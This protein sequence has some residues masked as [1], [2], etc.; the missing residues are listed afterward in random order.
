MNEE[1]LKKILFLILKVIIKN[2]GFLSQLEIFRDVRYYMQKFFNIK[3]SDLVIKLPQGR[4]EDFKDIL[5]FILTILCEL[6]IVSQKMENK[7]FYFKWIGFKGFRKKYLIEFI[8]NNQ[9]NFEMSDSFEHRI[10]IY[11]RM[12]IMELFKNLDTGVVFNTLEAFMKTCG[13][14]NQLKHSEKIHWILRWINFLSD[15]KPNQIFTLLNS[16][17]GEQVAF[18]LNKVLSEESLI[19]DNNYAEKFISSFN[20]FIISKFDQFNEIFKNE[21]G[22]KSSEMDVEMSDS[23]NLSGNKIK[24]LPVEDLNTFQ[25]KSET[26]ELDSMKQ[27]ISKFNSENEETGFAVLRGTNWCYYL[28][29]LFCIIGRA[30][31]KYG[32]AV[33]TLNKLNKSSNTQQVIPVPNENLGNTTW[34][35]DLDLGQ[36]KKISKQHA[37]ISYNFQTCSFEIVNLSKKYPIKVNGELIN[38]GEDM[39]LSSKSLISIGSQEFVFLLAL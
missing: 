18:K 33:T 15:D 17:K 34:H 3:E 21:A 30:P 8:L 25:T 37:L 13:L 39:P 10:Q 36:N 19:K 23:G 1:N 12:V 24:S 20:D 4:S 6:A 31:I 2:N 7:S 26:N 35:V 27:S 22:S 11:T 28:K 38:F 5:N 29:K 14:D 16:T 32:V 9:T